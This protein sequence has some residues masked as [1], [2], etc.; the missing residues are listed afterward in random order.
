MSAAAWATIPH[1]EVTSPWRLATAAAPFLPRGADPYA[2]RTDSWPNEHMRLI[3]LELVG[4]K[5]STDAV[6]RALKRGDDVLLG[7]DP[8]Q[9]IPSR[10][11]W[12]P[13]GIAEL[14]RRLPSGQ[15]HSLL[16]HP[17]SVIS[18]LDPE[19]RIFLVDSGDRHDPEHAYAVLSAALPLPLLPAWA[20][21]LLEQGLC[22]GLVVKLPASGF[23][24]AEIIPDIDGW[25]TLIQSGLQERI[26]ECGS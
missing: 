22:Q 1:S 20:P 14:A 4:P 15:M 23:A 17:Q 16:L 3:A 11:S 2:T 6:R 18:R 13:G 9:N 19:G 26:L 12:A 21:W 10:I 25:A 24:A 8:T 7:G 5:A